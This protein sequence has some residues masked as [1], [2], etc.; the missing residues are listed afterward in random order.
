[1]TSANVPGEPMI[2]DDNAIKEL[3]ADAYLLHDQPII[4]RADDTVVR[5][6]DGK[7]QF[8]R[9]SSWIDT[10]EE[11]DPEQVLSTQEEKR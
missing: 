3:G 2:I 6:F 5:I 4:N 9:R 10:L 8:I 11:Y 1:M 7:T